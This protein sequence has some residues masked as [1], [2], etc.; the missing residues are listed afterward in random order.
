M[1]SVE[2]TAITSLNSPKSLKTAFGRSERPPFT[3]KYYWRARALLLDTVDIFNRAG[4]P[5]Q[6]T[7]VHCWA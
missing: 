1:Q 6:L 7:Q 2:T 4:F 3:G 5:T